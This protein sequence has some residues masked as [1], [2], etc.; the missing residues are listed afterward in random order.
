MKT[1]PCQ[2]AE[3]VVD[4]ADLA[5]KIII[6]QKELQKNVDSKHRFNNFH[7]I[8]SDIHKTSKDSDEFGKYAQKIVF[9]GNSQQVD[10]I[11]QQQAVRNQKKKLE[12]EKSVKIFSIA[13]RE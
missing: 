5:V 8:C 6:F 10:L 11:N 3:S 7:C 2:K 1:C 13:I 9:F 4:S 12:K